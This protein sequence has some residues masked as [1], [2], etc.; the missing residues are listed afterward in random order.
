MS[1]CLVL[2]DDIRQHAVPSGQ[3]QAANSLFEQL[4][5]P[6]DRV[7]VVCRGV[8]ADDDVAAA[9]GEAFKDR[10]ENFELV[11][12]GAVRLNARTKVLRRAYGDGAGGEWIEQRTRDR[13]QVFVG[14]D[15]YDG[16]NYLAAEREVVLVDPCGGGGSENDVFELSDGERVEL[17]V[18]S[19]IAR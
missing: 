18:E 2:F 15:L 14:H 5:E 17:A 11:V 9:V 4:F 16:G 19:T 6:N 12:A 8:E 13:R 7:V 1:L 3:L 10:K